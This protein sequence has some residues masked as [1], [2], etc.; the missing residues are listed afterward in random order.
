MNRPWNQITPALGFLLWSL[1]SGGTAWAQTPAEQVRAA[2]PEAPAAQ[3]APGPGAAPPAAAP[4]DPGSATQAP[5][6][7]PAPGAATAAPA[8]T[9]PA[10]PARPASTGGLAQAPD[11]LARALEPRAE[12]TGEIFQGTAAKSDGRSDWFIPLSQGRCYLFSGAG[13]ATVEKLFFFLWDPQNSRVDTVKPY[14]ALVSS[15]Y[16]APTSGTYHVQLKVGDGKGAYALGTY[17]VPG[18]APAAPVNL[19]ELVR[20]RA[21]AAGASALPYGTPLP[22]PAPGA[23]RASWSLNLD[24][25]ACYWFVG[26]GD[27]RVKSS[28]LQLFGPGGKLAVETPNDSPTPALS[29]CTEVAATVNLQARIG[30]DGLYRTLVYSRPMPPR[31]PVAVAAAGAAAPAATP[32]PAAAPPPPGPSG[33]AKAMN[34]FG[35]V[36]GAVDR[37]ASSVQVSATTSRTECV[38]G[39]CSGEVRTST[40]GNPQPAAPGVGPHP[41]GGPAFPAGFGGAAAV[42]APSPG[43]AS[44]DA[45]RAEM[46]RSCSKGADCSS[47]VCAN[48]SCS[49]SCGSAGDCPSGWVCDTLSGVMDKA[50]GGRFSD[51]QQESMMRAAS[52]AMG[53]VCFRGR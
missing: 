22:A 51:G 11:W 31:A 2:A 24:P 40:F 1:S 44:S 38:N 4:A 25:G 30:G 45:A 12:R 42:Q 46:G 9:A 37:A 8:P 52:D 7:L 5:A 10:A 20:A 47:G 35:K 26:A 48:G 19:E 18:P 6:A 34:V 23:G 27:A 53:R 39:R 36:T 13:D 28:K 3:P 21:A 50:S 29:Y 32:N 43:A 17:V 16:C 41:V 15:R 14:G 33:F 49:K